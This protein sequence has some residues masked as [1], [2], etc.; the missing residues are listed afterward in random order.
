VTKVVYSQ[1]AQRRL[2]E[3]A[4][5][6]YEKSGSVDIA[7]GYLDQM[8]HYITQTLTRFPLAGRPAEEFAPGVRKLVYQGFSILYRISEERID[9]L[10][11]YRENR[12]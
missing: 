7:D 1:K 10:T 2:I 6:I 8:D 5:Y 4:R 11:L 12:P 3:A 9:I